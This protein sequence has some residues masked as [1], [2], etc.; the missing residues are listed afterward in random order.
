MSRLD[1]KRVLFF[2]T[3]LPCMGFSQQEQL[4]AVYITD[5]NKSSLSKAIEESTRIYIDEQTIQSFPKGNGDV[6]EILQYLPD[7]KVD[8]NRE[9]S[10]NA[11]EL[12]PEDISISGAK[13]YENNYQI[14]GISNNSLLDPANDN[15][16]AV[17]DV[18][19]NTQEIFLDTDIIKSVE[20]YDSDVPAR[21][22]KFLGG[23]IDTKTK[24]ATGEFGG[25]IS[26]RYTSDEFTKFFV[27]DQSG[28]Q[29]SNSANKQPKFEKEFL[30]LSLN[31]PVSDDSG[32]YFNTVLKNSTIPLKHFLEPKEQT[33]ISYNFFGKYSKFFEDDSVLDVSLSHAPY[34]EERFLTNVKNSDF[35]IEGGGTKGN[36]AYEKE[37]E[38]F[39]LKSIFD[40]SYSQNSKYASKD[41]YNWATTNEKNWGMILG[42]PTSREGGFGDIEKEQTIFT[43]KNDLEFDFFNAGFELGKGEASFERLEDS[44]IY[45]VSST[46]D[47]AESGLVKLDCNGMDGCIDGDQYAVSKDTYHAFDST[48]DIMTASGYMEKNIQFERLN[49]RLGVR[50]DYNDYMKN[51]D[52]AYR[53]LS[54][55][56]LFDDRK[57]IF[58][59]GLNRYY[60][61]S[62]LTYKLREGKLPYITYTRGLLPLI[63]D[64]GN[65][66]F[67][68]EQWSQSARTG[69]NKNRYSDLETPLQRRDNFFFKS[70]AFWR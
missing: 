7:I 1:I 60:S 17:N 53:S 38:S 59:V 11:G 14:D 50:Y 25:K 52:L 58:S 46:D 41:F 43:L 62:F 65:Q 6:N 21:F 20:V 31:L 32:I 30:G 40:I 35:T 12:T 28:F 56:D 70:K 16:N 39:K 24:H 42:E 47:S 69:T 68:P 64:Y 8:S 37:F 36:A 33:R 45:R 13:F 5:G 55:W 44:S 57:T 23:V 48:A 61:N 2:S 22:G 15:A 3:L 10:F 9:T 4:K 66:Y 51:H 18:K 27:D 63:D 67:I 19:G 34:K 54:S 29:N 26:Y 49:F